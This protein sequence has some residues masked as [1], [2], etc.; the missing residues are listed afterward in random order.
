ME[1][2]RCGLTFAKVTNPNIKV[3]AKSPCITHPPNQSNYT[4][5]WET[6]IGVLLR[7]LTELA[8]STLCTRFVAV[9]IFVLD[10]IIR[11]VSKRDCTA[12]F[13]YDNH[14]RLKMGTYM[15]ILFEEHKSSLLIIS[16]IFI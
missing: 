1:N 14:S 16:K 4:A 13:K 11:H 7:K 6:K 12:C 10:C 15:M 3:V 5:D 9:P 8:S 2:G